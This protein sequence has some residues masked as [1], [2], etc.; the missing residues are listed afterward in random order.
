MFPATGPPTRAC[1]AFQSLTSDN[2]IS[3]EGHQHLQY[4]TLCATA[5][6]HA[7]INDRA[8]ACMKACRYTYTSESPHASKCEH[9][10]IG[11]C[12]PTVRAR[13]WPYTHTHTNTASGW[14]VN[15][16]SHTCTDRMLHCVSC[17]PNASHK[18]LLHLR[19][20]HL[21]DSAVAKVSVSRDKSTRKPQSCC[22]HVL[23]DGMKNTAK[24]WCARG[25]NVQSCWHRL[26]LDTVR[27][28]G[29][30]H[31]QGLVRQWAA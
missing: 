29:Q 21:V 4:K 15:E 13:S 26:N 19:L 16:R 24:G 28:I 7:N 12:T 27:N 14:C 17:Q 20:A 3:D 23:G 22:M 31:R 9:A 11:K 5:H 8:C 1:G 6:V 10:H 18:H 2:G 30:E 25:N